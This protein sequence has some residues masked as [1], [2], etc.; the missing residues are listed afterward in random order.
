MNSVNG[1]TYDGTIG[2]ENDRPYLVDDEIWRTVRS[3]KKK[4][5]HLNTY[6]SITFQDEGNIGSILLVSGLII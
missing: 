3:K 4:R 6:D 2:D 1:E 5:K